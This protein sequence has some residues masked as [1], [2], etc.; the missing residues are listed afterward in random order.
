M[1][2]KVLDNDFIMLPQ[3]AL[4]WIEAKTI[5][6][7]DLHL[8]KITHFRKEGIALPVI[9][10]EN[11]FKRLDE[12]LLNYNAS[13]IIF[14]GDLFH[15]RHNQEWELFTQWRE[16]HNSIEMIIVLGNHDIIPFNL[17]TKN[18]INVLDDLK[19]GKF[20]FTHHPKINFESGT[21]TFCG[22]VHPV[23]CL[24]SKARQS[25]KL[26][27]FVFDQQQAI[28]PSFGVF[29]GGYEMKS[30][31]NR[32]IFLITEDKIIAA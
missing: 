26:P 27:C 3:K 18:K 11:N 8:G 28:L 4:Y 14:L 23:Y 21:F 16:K 9:A 15:N 2:I 19:E 7:S 12:I 5:L 29:T 20:L 13:R 25:L 1:D 24:K 22:H 30:Q 32:K 10:F 6:I 31:Y 17:F